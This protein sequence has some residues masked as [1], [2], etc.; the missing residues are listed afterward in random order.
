MTSHAVI[1][2]AGSTAVTLTG[3]GADLGVLDRRAI[4]TRDCQPYH[5][6]Q[7]LPIGQAEKLIADAFDR[8]VARATDDVR[9]LIDGLDRDVAMA[10]I[11][12]KEYRLPSSIEVRLRSHPM[13][14]GAEGEMTRD[15]LWAACEALGLHVHASPADAIDPRAEG[16]GKVIGAPWRKEHKLAATA[17]LGALRGH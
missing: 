8:A 16:V 9:A 10:G 7:G 14:H 5:D 6:A 12:F 1:G 17:A 15:A 4:R 13:C 11:S 2:L 3:V